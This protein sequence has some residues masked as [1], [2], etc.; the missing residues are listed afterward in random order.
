M[1]LKEKVENALRSRFQVDH[2]RLLDDD[3]VY[4]FVVSPDFRGLSAIDRQTLIDRALRDPAMKLTKREHR[5]VLAIAP[6][7]P[8]EFDVIGPVGVGSRD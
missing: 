2:I 3:G 4:G 5:Q 6:M 8:V 1:E 7:T